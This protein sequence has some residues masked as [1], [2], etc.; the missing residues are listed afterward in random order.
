L[1]SIILLTDGLHQSGPWGDEVSGQ[2]GNYIE[3]FSKNDSTDDTRIPPYNY[4]KSPVRIARENGVRIYSVG[5]R[6]T[7]ALYDADFLEGISL[8]ESIGTNGDF[9]WGNDSLSLAESFLKA[10][11]AASGWVELESRNNTVI[12]TNG[13]HEIFSLYV[14]SSIRRLK[15]DVNWND[16]SVGFNISIR[17]PNGSIFTIPSIGGEIPKNIVI[18]SDELPKSVVIDFPSN[19]TWQF[20]VTAVNIPPAGELIKARVSSYNPPIF[21][22]S[23]NELNEVNSNVQTNVLYAINS[24]KN[25]SDSENNSVYFELNVTN[26]NPSFVFHNI[27]P[28]VIGLVHENVTHSWTPSAVGNLSIDQSVSFILNVTFLN[29]VLFEGDLNFRVDCDEGYFDAYNQ[30]AAFGYS[31]EIRYESSFITTQIVELSSV[32]EYIP[33]TEEFNTLKWF[34]LVISLILLLSFL[35]V[36]VRAQQV[37]IRNI[38]TRFRSRLFPDRSVLEHALQREGIVVSPT[39]IDTIMVEAGDLDRL[40]E[41]IYETTGK[42]LATEDLIRVASGTNVDKIAQRISF[43]TGLSNQEVLSRLSNA[44]SIDEL[45]QRLE[46]D[47]ERFLD[48]IARDEDV[49]TFQKQVKGLITPKLQINSGIIM[50]EDLDIARFRSRLKKAQRP[51]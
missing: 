51:K 7:T 14:N 48:I 43:A 3:W 17:Q 27:T 38:A 41:A 29:P 18:I 33:L 35:G 10:K 37:R 26:R 9:F 13:N 23:V 47:K 8:N 4:S 32:L 16:T 45:I 40:G 24:V 49:L 30:P 36:Y 34:G 44:Q 22:E 31:A 25:N 12:T 46:L 42:R 20:N 5:I 19:G 11:D 39:E 21:I 28:S 2:L 50:N 15:Y 1:K 6:G